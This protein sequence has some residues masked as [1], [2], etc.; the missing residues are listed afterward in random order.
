M[1]GFLTRGIL[2]WYN[3]AHVKEL[4]ENGS[5]ACLTA[6]DHDPNGAGIAEV[7]YRLFKN[8]RDDED[9]LMAFPEIGGRCDMCG[10]PTEFEFCEECQEKYSYLLA[11][12]IK[13]RVVSRSCETKGGK[14][15]GR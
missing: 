15:G 10:N 5:S 3:F 8:Y 7:D 14:D 13:A 12:V 9:L 1:R 11:K 6:S 2:F 4:L